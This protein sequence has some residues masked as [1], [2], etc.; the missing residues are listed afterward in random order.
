MTFSIANSSKRVGKRGDLDWYEWEIHLAE[1][2]ERL[3]QVKR[4]VYRLH[5]TFPN[6]VRVA[7]DA[8]SGFSLKSSGWG[9][10]EVLATISLKDGSE[11]HQKYRLK[12]GA[13]AEL[14]S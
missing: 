13:K 2:P 11:V 1:P 12:L 6:P 4:V 10:F 14:E 8:K 3:R 5:P 9:E 7:Q